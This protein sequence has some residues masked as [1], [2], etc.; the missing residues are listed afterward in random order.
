MGTIVGAAAGIIL[1]TVFGI[2]PAFR[3]G[4]YLALFIL[5]K[6]TGKSVEPSVWARFFIISGALVSIL[7]GAGF[8][9]VIGSL[10]GHVLLF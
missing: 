1:F 7:M 5:Q 6:A 4:S 8:F 9:A 2:M 10:I 3:F